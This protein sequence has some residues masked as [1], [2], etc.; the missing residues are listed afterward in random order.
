MLVDEVGGE[1]MKEF[2]KI[3]HKGMYCRIFLSKDNGQFHVGIFGRNGKL[4][5]ISQNFATM[6]DAEKCLLKI[7][8]FFPA[9]VYD[10]KPANYF[11]GTL[12]GFNS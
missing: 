10:P 3:N 8:R 4:M 12:M 5:F 11:F 6:F 1:A 2:E 7:N 9:K